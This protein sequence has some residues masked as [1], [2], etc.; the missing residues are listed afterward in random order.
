MKKLLVLLVLL[1]LG[2]TGGALATGAIN[3]GHETTTYRIET[4]QQYDIHATV[5]ATGTIQ[6]EEVVDVGAQVAGKITRLGRDLEDKRKAIDYCSRVREGTLLA[7]I[8]ADL[9][10]ARETQAKANL[11]QAVATVELNVAKY[12]QYERDWVRARKMYSGGTQGISE[13]DLDLARSNYETSKANVDVAKAAVDVC[14][15]AL[16]EATTNLGYTKIVS[17]VDGVIIDRRVNV[18]QTVVASLNAPSLFLIAKDLR[19]MVIWAS[20]NEAD[21]GQVQRAKEVI[22]TV[23]TDTKPLQGKVTQVRYNASMNSGVVTYTVV[24]SFDNSEA[25]L[26]PYLTASLKFEWAEAN[27]VLSLPNSVLRWRPQV[28]NVARSKRPDWGPKLRRRNQ[29]GEKGALK[30]TRDGRDYFTVWVEDGKGFV[31][32]REVE[33]GLTDGINTEIKSGLK[34]GDK[35]VSGVER[36]AESSR[37]LFLEG[38]GKMKQGGQ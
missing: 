11:A 27:R 10:A 29:E 34:E 3:F 9:Y 17:P 18:G 32:P 37:G 19:R 12:R 20:V 35:V 33:I 16:K 15:A 8:D 7:E 23:P 28:Q 2:A 13:A 25:H 6:P 22:F 36:V 38:I 5:S 4:V 1:A 24:V 30:V 26:L 14:Q 21:I 31:E